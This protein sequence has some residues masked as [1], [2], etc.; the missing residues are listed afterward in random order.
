MKRKAIFGQ[1]SNYSACCLLLII[2]LITSSGCLR[3]GGERG[4]PPTE[5]E[6]EVQQRL[7]SQQVPESHSNATLQRTNK[8]EYLVVAYVNYERL[9]SGREPLIWSPRLAQVADFRSYDMWNRDYFGHYDPEGRGE[10][11]EGV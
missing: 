11:P 4:H 9:E 8:V 7:N 2:L 1:Y 3:L 5:Y 10:S 6:P